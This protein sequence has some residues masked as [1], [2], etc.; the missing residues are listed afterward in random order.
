MPYQ[1]PHRRINWMTPLLWPA[2]DHAAKATN[3]SARSLLKYLQGRDRRK[4]R[5][6]KL[7]IGTISRW[8]DSKSKPRTWRPEVLERVRTGLCWKPS[9]SRIGM[10]DLHPDLKKQILNALISIRQSSLPINAVAAR[11]IM[12]AY[13]KAK[14]SEILSTYDKLP[15]PVISLSTVRRFLYQNL[16]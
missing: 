16:N 13:I 15:G 6:T 8:I 14:R 10:F 3:F 2:I 12:M 4:E 5:F 1:K 9:H 11:N 7:T